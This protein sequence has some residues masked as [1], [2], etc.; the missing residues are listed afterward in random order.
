M[1]CCIYP[2]G[3]GCG[4]MWH[5]NFYLDANLVSRAKR[6]SANCNTTAT[7]SESY[8]AAFDLGCRVVRTGRSI[9]DLTEPCET[10]WYCY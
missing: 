6:Y 8:K 5:S 7:D 3:R 2:R 10:G 1:T 9:V 4:D